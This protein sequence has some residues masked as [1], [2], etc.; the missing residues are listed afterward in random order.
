MVRDRVIVELASDIESKEKYPK[1]RDTD[2]VTLKGTEKRIILGKARTCKMASGKVN[3]VFDELSERYLHINTFLKL[4]NEKGERLDIESVKKVEDKRVKLDK[5]PEVQNLPS[6]TH[7][8]SNINLSTSGMSGIDISVP[9]A[10]EIN[11]G[12]DTKKD[13]EKIEDT[14]PYDWYLRRLL[15]RT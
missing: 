13:K 9:D 12:V 4:F 5:K 15:R 10:P 6:N 3:E 1:A 7:S 8:T 11:V 2:M 14:D